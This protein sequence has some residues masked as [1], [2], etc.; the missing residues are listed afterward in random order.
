MAFNGKKKLLYNIK[1]P[2]TMG[3]RNKGEEV[4][5][6]PNHT[7]KSSAKNKLS[8]LD[9]NPQIHFMSF[10]GLLL[11]IIFSETNFLHCSSCV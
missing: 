11:C 5:I 2:A 9:V 8:I 4:K 10:L 1:Q 7:V 3:I 6:N